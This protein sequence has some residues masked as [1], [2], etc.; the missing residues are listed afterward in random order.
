M[1][2][3]TIKDLFIRILRDKLIDIIIIWLIPSGNIDITI[4]LQ[5]NI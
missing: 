5:L 2:K 3:N 4:I 1:H